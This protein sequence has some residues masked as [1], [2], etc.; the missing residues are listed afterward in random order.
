MFK[1][2]Q[3]FMQRIR[4]IHF[5]G[6]G[7]AG[8][9][10]IAEVYNNL[11]YKVSGSDIKHNA[12]TKHLSS[13]GVSIHVEHKAENIAGCDVVVYSSA[14]DASNEELKAAQSQRIPIVP[15]A[16]M[17]AELMRFRNGIAVAGTHGK[18]T[19]TS[20]VAS[21]LAEGGL[22]PT[23][24]IGG[25]LNSSGRNAQLGSGNYLVAEADE[26]DA[27]FLHLQPM[28][29]VL[30]N[31][32]A[33]HLETYQGDLENLK[34]N[35]FEFIHRLPFY[36]LAII[37]IDDPIVQEIMPYINKPFITY[38]LNEEADI[39]GTIIK[40]DAERTTFSVSISGREDLII[41]LNMPGQH[42]TLNALAAVAVAHELEIDDKSIQNALANFQGISRRCEVLG[43][44]R[45][46][47]KQVL[48]I[49][50]YAHH[51]REISAT[52]KAIRKGWSNKKINVVFQPHRYTRTRDLFED[53]A[54]VLSELD[55]LFILDVYSAGEH[56]IPG[57]DSRS[58][59][60][61]I[62]LR[63]SV[64]PIFVEDRNE[65]TQLLSSVV[66]DDEILL[67]LGAGNVGKI[68]KELITTHQV[69]SDE[70]LMS[71]V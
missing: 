5:V 62:R 2:G 71:N 14:I 60:R 31:I 64:D 25:L 68:A 38:G 33:D 18:T 58:L 28:V 41:D 49:D 67:I 17:L 65:I 24:V 7:G 30:T 50:D 46:T 34:Q 48:L 36:G 32:D 27:S 54:A 43:N 53:F 20:L 44:I 23:Y 3:D 10:G 56:P 51:P 69:N 61:A 22:D 11:G 59:C 52:I 55:A 66:N 19:T 40:Q 9:S 39:K 8:M 13:L 16:E 1:S 37:C 45:L 12:N 63:G 6:I 26:S 57:A 15:R 47:D 4:H 29:S 70:V 42:N 35:F 21:V